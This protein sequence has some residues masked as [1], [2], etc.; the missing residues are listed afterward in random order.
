MCHGPFAEHGPVEAFAVKT[1]NDGLLVE[2]F[3]RLLD[4]RSFFGVI[5]GQELHDSQV[6]SAPVHQADQ[7]EGIAGKPAGFEVY[8]EDL[9]GAGAGEASEVAATF[10]GWFGR[11]QVL[12]ALFD[13][14][15]ALWSHCGGTGG[16][17]IETAGWGLG[18][19]A[20]DDLA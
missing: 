5:T 16:D 3:S 8:I 15:P 11:E 12:P 10:D 1:D 7:K 17:A 13:E 14:V 4:Y 6:V 19:S 18:D 9:G 2:Q 20:G